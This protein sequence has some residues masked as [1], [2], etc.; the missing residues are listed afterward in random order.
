MNMRS[1]YPHFT[2]S[3]RSGG[4]TAVV[5][6]VATVLLL[7]GC[8][9]V[10]AGGAAIHS[11]GAA[12]GAVAV[13]GTPLNGVS[14]DA[15]WVEPADGVGNLVK[16]I[17]HAQGRIFVEDYILT[18]RRIVR[19]LERAEAQ[20]VDVYVMLEPH[21]FGMGTQP[22]HIA[23]ELR[24]AGISFRWSSPAFALTHAK[25]MVID[26]RI[27]VISTANFSLSGFKSDRDFVVIDRNREDVQMV[28]QIFR[29]DW[30][31]LPVTDS[32]RHL[33]VSP[34]DSRLRMSSLIGKS[35]QSVDVFSEELNDR[36]TERLLATTARR[37]IAVRV[38]LPSAAADPLFLSRAGV[39]IRILTN[40]YI[41]AKA[42]I[43]DGRTAFVGSENL[44]EQSLDRNREVG[45]LFSGPAV[46][47]LLAVFQSDWRQGKA[48]G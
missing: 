23:D 24:A 40:P 30:D 26:D 44:S 8:G 18:H 25:L 42:I 3:S 4:I 36:A 43:V 45:V 41:H 38:I 19:A 27:A 17:D 12:G 39:Q 13:P 15:L 31:R 7:G 11:N 1:V 48:A 5:L 14:S 10:T 22:Q 34:V 29:E 35:R 6:A 9:V 32:D 33:V 21:P 37:H 20:G 2:P 16:L 28:S 47:S 46:R